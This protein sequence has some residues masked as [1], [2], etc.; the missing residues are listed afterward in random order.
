M[1]TEIV[2][3][4]LRNLERVS[5]SPDSK[6][7]LIVG[8]NGSGKTSI[9]EGIYL[10]GRARSFLTNKYKS[11]VQQGKTNC[12]VF[13]RVA[14]DDHSPS[15]SIGVSRSVDGSSQ[16]K[17]SGQKVRNSAPLIEL[18]PT[19]V[20]NPVSFSLLTGGPGG[21]RQF[22]D[23]GVFHVEHS[24]L[25]SWQKFSRC[26]KQRNGLLRQRTVGAKELA[27]WN[28]EF[29]ECAKIITAQ[30]DR[31]LASFAPYFKKALKQLTS[32]DD[33]TLGFYQGWDEKLELQVVLEDSFARDQKRGFTHYGPQR[34]DIK[35]KYL[36]MDAGE[37]LSRGQQ[38]MVVCALKVA[39][40][41]FFAESTGRQSLYL[42]DDLT[43]ELDQE[44]QLKLCEMLGEI[45][46]QVFAT[47]VDISSFSEIW[48]RKPHSMF[49]VE[50]GNLIEAQRVSPHI[51]RS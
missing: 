43:A 50:Q 16:I 48:S 25:R 42:I 45:K 2:I 22:V 9:L 29:V 24:F 47:S 10:L 4:H 21:R 37:S 36:G 39:Q 32:L 27:P 44:H 51:W 1:L 8:P 49:H 15:L 38:K 6:I 17:V 11:I 18:L 26:L 40:G 13:G 19:Q 20:I 33:I 46:C 7:N 3:T 23:W 30:R 28:E 12:T 35:I 14:V 31:Y 41:C 34:A 5:F